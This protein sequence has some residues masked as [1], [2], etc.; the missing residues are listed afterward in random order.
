M[1]GEQHAASGLGPIEGYHA[2]VYARPGALAEELAGLHRRAQQ[3]LS[4]DRVGR[5]REEPVGPHPVAMFQIAL[6]PA[7]LAGLVP[8][9]L[10][11][12]GDRSI[13]IHPL[14]G[15]H[16]REHSD[17]ALWIGPRLELDL[18]FFD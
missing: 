9:L 6:E 3:E 1:E 15:D 14:H 18:S 12:H 4:E 16:L 7:R 5:L 10:A 11:H 17:D 8:W 2:H 13:L